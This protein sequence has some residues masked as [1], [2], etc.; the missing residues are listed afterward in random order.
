[1]VQLTA[2]EFLEDLGDA[3]PLQIGIGKAEQLKAIF[4]KSMSTR[5]L[6]EP[7]RSKIRLR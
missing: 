2:N 7:K 4:V 6:G 1:M 5:V 3:Q